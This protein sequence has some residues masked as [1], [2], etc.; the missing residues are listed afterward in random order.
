MIEKKTEKQIIISG[1]V[2]EVQDIINELCRRNPG[3]KLIELNEKYGEDV[4][5]FR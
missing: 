1:T 2:K 4:L 3:K 5:I